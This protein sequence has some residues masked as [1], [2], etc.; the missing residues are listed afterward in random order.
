MACLECTWR[1]TEGPEA[2]ERELCVGIND[3]RVPTAKMQRIRRLKKGYR[4]FGTW[5]YTFFLHKP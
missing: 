2:E 5:A 4:Q 1:G 3:I